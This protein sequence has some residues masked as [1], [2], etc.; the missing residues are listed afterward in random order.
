MTRSLAALLALLLL[1]A[2][3]APARAESGDPAFLQH[4]FAPELV[5]KN[6]A[7]ISLSSA[8]RSA[9]L[10]DIGRVSGSTTELQLS[11][12]DGF[13]AVEELSAADPVDEKALLEA[14]HG[15]LSAELRVKEAH[16]GLLVRVRNLLTPEQR[17]K[18]RALRD[19]H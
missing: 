11:M 1:L 16:M 8:Q 10:K 5:L 2:A 15:V 6:A 19:G 4:F 13:S 12:L 14:I 7:A 9:L 18:L 3:A 17:E